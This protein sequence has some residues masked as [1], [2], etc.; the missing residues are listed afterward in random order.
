MS[1]ASA[2]ATLRGV[3]ADF[4]AAALEAAAPLVA[5]LAADELASG[6]RASAEDVAAPPSP[7][8]VTVRLTEA[9]PVADGGSVRVVEAIAVDVLGAS[10]CVPE[11]AAALARVLTAGA[12]AR[13]WATALWRAGV[14]RVDVRTA[15]PTDAFA[16]CF[17]YLA[18]DEIANVQDV[19]ARAW[20]LP[21]LPAENMAK[22]EHMLGRGGFQLELTCRAPGAA[23]AS[24]ETLLPAPP[25]F[26]PVGAMLTQLVHASALLAPHA[27]L[28]LEMET[29]DAAAALP[30]DQHNSHPATD[31]ALVE[32]TAPALRHSV[33]LSVR[34]AAGLLSSAERVTSAVRAHL[35]SS[36]VVLAV[37]SGDVQPAAS[38]A[39]D[40]AAAAEG[41]AVAAAAANIAV[42]VGHA[43]HAS[44]AA[45]KRV[46]WSFTAVVARHGPA[47]ELPPSGDAALGDT[48]E[49]V[50][51]VYYFC[52]SALQATLTA[53]ALDHL[54][55]KSTVEAWRT[56]FGLRLR[57]CRAA[58]AEEEDGEPPAGAA[59]GAAAAELRFSVRDADSAHTPTLL[60]LYRRCKLHQP[61]LKLPPLGRKREASLVKAA[62]A[63]AL[64]EFKAVTGFGTVFERG[65]RSHGLPAVA[66]AAIKIIAGGGP[67]LQQV[68]ADFFRRWQER[69]L[70][71]A[72]SAHDAGDVAQPDVE[73]S[74]LDA[75]RS[76]L[77]LDGAAGLGSAAV[78][79]DDSNA[80]RSAAGADDEL[81]ADW[82]DAL[83]CAAL[84]SEGEEVLSLSPARRAARARSADDADETAAAAS[85]DDVFP[86][87]RAKRRMGTSPAPAYEAPNRVTAA[88]SGSDQ[89]GWFM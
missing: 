5:D 56:A 77:D 32:P 19:D 2:L 58:A 43:E 33:A 79:A 89:D 64:L 78:A 11:G 21:L 84:Y 36:T 40:G 38:A 81:A 87:Q 22:P 68:A 53:G 60:V 24:V 1:A 23:Q 8:A 46:V 44:G 67:G 9:A 45:D 51:A 13:E 14:T 3:C 61:H 55:A 65:L 63:A 71:P 49:H 34:C 27:E 80:E 75:L 10:P 12:P 76:A 16:R 20:A 54:R 7:P 25:A 72:S 74:M 30:A 59:A 48:G 42:A 88:D 26:A 82:G 57:G 47:P 4:L 17:A 37:P 6:R 85:V 39:A 35:L 69:Q 86:A 83:P 70:L 28:Q 62:V 73:R 29:F 41:A 15:S 50:A 18:S 52:Q 31:V 66:G